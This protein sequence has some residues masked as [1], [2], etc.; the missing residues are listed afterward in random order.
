MIQKLVIDKVM[1]LVLKELSKQIKPLQKYVDEP[2]ELDRKVSDL[3]YRIDALESAITKKKKKK[4]K[5][6]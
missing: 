6:K 2:N 5:N 4:G 3:G 1:K